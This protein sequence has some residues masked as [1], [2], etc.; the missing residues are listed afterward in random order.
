MRRARRRSARRRR[1]PPDDEPRAEPTAAADRVRV[2]AAARLRRR[3]RHG[4]PRR[5]HA[6][7]DGTRRARPAAR[8]PGAGEPGVPHGRAARPGRHPARHARRRARRH[9]SRTCSPPTLPSCRTSTGG[10]TR[11]ATPA[12]RVTC[13]TLR[14]RV[15]GRRGRWPPGGIVTY[16]ADRLY[17]EVAY[18]AYHFTG[19]STSSSTWSTRPP[20]L[21]REI[22]SLAARGRSEN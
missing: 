14:A 9:R 1:E 16:A 15:H 17:E 12:P 22:Q 18:V 8:R 7:G 13:P 19:R 5:G 10:S 2:R 20:P 4:A 3:R 21:R 6:A 11:R